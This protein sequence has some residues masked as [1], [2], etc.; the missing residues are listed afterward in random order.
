M[1]TVVLG[2]D[3]YSGWP[4]TL[5]LIERGDHVVGV[6][7]LSRRQ[8]ALPSVTPIAP[9]AERVDA[10]DAH[11]DGELEFYEADVTTYENVY[12]LLTTYEPHT[13][14]NLAQIPSAPYSMISPRRAWQTQQNNIQ[15]ALNLFWAIH[16]LGLDTHVVQLATMGEYPIGAD[17]PE[18]FLADGRPAPKDPG[19]FYHACYDDETEVL[20]REGWK[21][22]ADLLE[23]D[24]VM[25]MDAD[26]GETGWQQ[27]SAVQAYDYEGEL[28]TVT[29]RAVD[30][31]VTPN[32]RM[33]VGSSW[34]NGHHKTF[35]RR[36]IVEAHDLNGVPCFFTAF[37]EWDGESPDTFEIPEVDWSDGWNIQRL[38][39]REVPMEA[40]VRFFGWW[41]AEGTV[42]KRGQT[43][44]VGV[45]QNKVAD[46]VDVFDAIGYDAT[47]APTPTGQVARVNDKQLA[48]HLRQFGTQPERFIPEWM[49][50]LSTDLLD[51]L[52][53]ALIEGDGTETGRGHTF[54]TASER[55]ADDVQEIALKTGHRAT[56]SAVDR[57]GGEGYQQRP[58][59][60]VNIA[61]SW[62]VQTNQQG[63]AFGRQQYEGKV[64]CCTVDGGVILVRRNGKP[65]WCGN[66]KVNTTVN[67]Y[68][69]A[70]TWGIPTTEIYQGIVYGVSM[71]EGVDERLITRFDADSVFGTV[72]NRFT[73][74]AAV[75]HP[76]TVYGAGG[77]K[78]AMLSLPDCIQCLTLAIDNPP[79]PDGGR[80]PY[81]AINQFDGS[82]RVRE[83]AEL[84][85]DRTGAA[86]AHLD[87][88]R[89]ED[90]SDH[91]Y[92]P[93]R[94][95]LDELGYEPTRSLEDEFERTYEVIEG[96]TDRIDEGD[97]RPE[98]WW[99]GAPPEPIEVPDGGDDCVDL[100]DGGGCVEA[101]EAF[102]ERRRN[103]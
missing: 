1:T 83:L 61:P 27:P 72:L 15:G 41:L 98:T 37:P 93:E 19:S 46:L 94:E 48:E 70:K 54:F 36:T 40:W 13:V 6:D 77:Q 59:Y 24:E 85:A 58:E 86:I 92:D 44:T 10:A 38:K 42:G 63:E 73:A 14:V 90:E 68:F 80:Y 39:G 102:S 34:A 21:P 16:D 66:S 91:V 78:R 71:Y 29:N 51:V 53:S 20:T 76:L 103:D 62:A 65:V 56:I 31:A 100:G 50:N 5:N 88:P 22:F 82:Y 49:K 67:T 28:V 84:V 45:Y 2:S 33:F 52:L 30:L 87:N 95:V 81:R 11:F 9:P 101:W 60:R 79:D 74:Q 23:T 97:L 17:I 47:A 32:H 4:L 26:S 55:L 99:R 43:N 35:H 57:A 25:A 69:A 12:N 89:V 64:Y 75:D 3:G 96:H 7:D 18:G 8:R